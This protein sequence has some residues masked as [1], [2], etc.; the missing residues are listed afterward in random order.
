[1]VEPIPITEICL[2]VTDNCNLSC[3]LC[4]VQQKPNNISY[5]VAE[6]TMKWL[7]ENAKVRGLEK[8]PSCGFFGGEP[9]L[10]WNDIIVPIVEKYNNKISFGIT[11]NGLL[12]DENKLKFMKQHQM[13]LLFS[14][15]GDKESQDKNRPCKDGSSSFD[16]LENIFPLII[17]Y[18]PEATFRSTISKNS[19]DKIFHNIMFAKEKGFSS[20][21]AIPNFFSNWRK[22]ELVT[23]AAQMR[24]YSLYFINCF[25]EKKDLIIFHPLTQAFN[26]IHRII[27]NQKNNKTENKSSHRC[28]IGSGYGSVDYLGRIFGCQEMVTHDETDLFLVGNIYDGINLNK[29][30]NLYNMYINNDNTS[31]LCNYCELKS[32][33]ANESCVANNWLIYKDIN[34]N[35]SMICWWYNLLINEAIFIANV[36]GNQKNK[37]FKMY[38]FGARRLYN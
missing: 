16:I 23:I 6:D 17:K 7:L 14:C 26:K 13:S 31:S 12:L 30:N 27:H 19:Y 4:F 29:F 22:E 21:F 9:L 2:N 32:I 33:C 38:F 24:A 20:Y 11:T 10:V 18:Y 1:M 28:G 37:D 3:H 15:D 35:S 8:K 36:L 5:K 25:M 34:K